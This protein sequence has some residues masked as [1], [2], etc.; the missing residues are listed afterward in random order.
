MVGCFA[1]TFQR[2]SRRAG[3]MISQERHGLPPDNLERLPRELAA[4]TAEDVQ[5][6]ARAHLHPDAVCVA[7]AGPIP[8]ADLRAIVERTLGHA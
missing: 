1:L 4:V 8:E 2:D 7:A 5:R 3:Y 6:V